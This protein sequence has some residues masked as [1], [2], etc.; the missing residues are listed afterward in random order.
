M[1]VGRTLMVIGALI[2]AVGFVLTLVDRV[3]LLGRL[4]GDITLQGDRWT[5]FAPIATMIVLSIVL[6]LALNVFG[7]LSRR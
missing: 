7:W 3:P 4:P 1:D 5:V 6:T 2:L